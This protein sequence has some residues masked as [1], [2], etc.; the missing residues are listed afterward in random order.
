MVDGIVN[1]CIGPGLLVL[2]GITHGDSQAN[3]VRLT[4]KLIHL[5]IFPNDAGKMD[6]SCLDVRGEILLVSQFTLCADTWKGRR[7]SFESAARPDVAKPL[8]DF[9]V[10]ATRDTGLV[11]QT[12][13]FQSH[14][15]IELVNDGP[16]TLLL[17]S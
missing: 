2:V 14:M 7:P 17:E 10:Q 12:G 1:G 9:V 4:D 8:F 6:K 5:R 15:Q 13:V 3:A 16:V 11:V